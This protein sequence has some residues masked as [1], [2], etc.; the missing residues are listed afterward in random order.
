MSTAP[1][2]AIAPTGGPPDEGVVP[3]VATARTM[4]GLAGDVGGACDGE[5]GWFEGLGVAERRAAGDGSWAATVGSAGGDDD[6]CFVGSAVGEGEGDATVHTSEN[7]T[8]GGCGCVLPESPDPHD[9]PSISPSPIEDEPAPDP[10]HVH[11]P[12]P[13]PCQ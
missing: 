11:P 6:G 1:A 8:R 2:A 3:E 10:A 7:R 4:T 5:W 13:L 12:E 9:Q